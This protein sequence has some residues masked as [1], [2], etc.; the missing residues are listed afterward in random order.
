MITTTSELSSHWPSAPGAT[1]ANDAPIAPPIPARN[2]PTKNVMAKTTSM[3]MPSA[4]TISWSSTPARMTMPM[5][6]RL[7]HSHSNTPTTSAIAEHEQAAGGVAL[8]ED[9]EEVGDRRRP[10]HPLGETA[11]AGQHLI[12]EDH[13]DRHRDQGLAEILALVPAQEH[14]LDDEAED[15]GDQRRRRAGARPTT[16]C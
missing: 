14:L 12:G 8:A 3:L 9:L 15:G 4:R 5:R 13:R 7:S 6:V 16:A 1:P 2:A 10:D 11:E